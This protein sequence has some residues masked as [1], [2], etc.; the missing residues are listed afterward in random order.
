MARELTRPAIFD[1]LRHRRNYAVT[2]ARIVLDFK[3]DGHFMGEEI[4]IEG[5]PRIVADVQGTDKI[6]RTIVRSESLV[7]LPKGPLASANTGSP[8][9]GQTCS[10]TYYFGFAYSGTLT[11]VAA[12][13]CDQKGSQVGRVN[14]RE[15][16]RPKV[17]RRSLGRIRSFLTSAVLAMP[18]VTFRHSARLGCLSLQRP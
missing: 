15:G 8:C 5:N 1:A 9:A 11:P 7:V 16:P 6:S 17:G 13:P 14:G 18:L 12:W 3:I 2:N 4:Q 10:V